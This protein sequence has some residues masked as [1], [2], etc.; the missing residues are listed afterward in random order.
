M[1]FRR[2]SKFL[3][4][5][6]ILLGTYSA[7]I[8]IPIPSFASSGPDLEVFWR[9]SKLLSQVLVLPYVTYIIEGMGLFLLFTSLFILN[10]SLWNAF[11]FL[12]VP[13]LFETPKG[14]I[15]SSLTNITVS[16]VVFTICLMSTQTSIFP[17]VA[18]LGLLTSF[19]TVI[20]PEL[21]SLA[22]FAFFSLLFF[23]LRNHRI[24]SDDARAAPDAMETVVVF[25]LSYGL[26]FYGFGTLLGLPTI[27]KEFWG[28]LST[29]YVLP[30]LQCKFCLCSFPVF[31]KHHEPQKQ[32]LAFTLWLSAEFFR[33]IP[34][35]SENAGFSI[36]SAISA[37]MIDLA[38]IVFICSSHSRLLR[39]FCLMIMITIYLVSYFI[40]RS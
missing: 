9:N 8:F 21:F 31:F 35:A 29:I 15:I 10:G 7:R 37:R 23:W 6:L 20:I 18:V 2:F 39:S 30:V 14:D 25:I 17:L 28:P 11:L 27:S 32:L 22:L 36:V 4:L 19:C 26:G 13:I 24:G 3:S 33:F 1:N 38:A 5:A 40:C 34:I 12:V 16:F